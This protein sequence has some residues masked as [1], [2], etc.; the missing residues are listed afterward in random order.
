LPDSR[1]FPSICQILAKLAKWSKMPFHVI[2]QTQHFHHMAFFEK[3]VTHFAKFGHVMSK[4]CEWRA[5][6]HHLYLSQCSGLTIKKG[7]YTVFHTF[8]H[9]Y[10]CC[11]IFPQTEISNNIEQII[12]MCL[13]D[14]LI[15]HLSAKQA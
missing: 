4:S 7:S 10:F 14:K 8:G 6:G 1:H 13:K 2:R 9:F 3:N 5:D 15:G 11:L 12:F